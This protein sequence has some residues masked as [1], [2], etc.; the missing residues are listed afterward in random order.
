[1]VSTAWQ[2]TSKIKVYIYLKIRKEEKAVP[3]V[4]AVMKETKDRYV[5]IDKI[6]SQTVAVFFKTGQ[7]FNST[8]EENKMMQ[9]IRRAYSD[10]I[11]ELYYRKH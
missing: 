10:Y 5:I 1:M 4:Y 3:K 2:Q 9:K 8:A 6:T 11:R 7:R